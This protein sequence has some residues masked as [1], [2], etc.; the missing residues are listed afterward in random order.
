VSVW[1]GICGSAAC[2]SL[3]SIHKR[4]LRRETVYFGPAR[5]RFRFWIF[6]IPRFSS[7]FAKT[8]RS[9]AAESLLPPPH[10]HGDCSILHLTPSKR[11]RS[12][13][14][15]IFNFIVFLDETICSHPESDAFQWQRQS[16]LLPS[17]RRHASSGGIVGDCYSSM[18][19]RIPPDDTCWHVVYR[20]PP[21]S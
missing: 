2:M 12:R 15:I 1:V 13:L 7:F 8:R 21:L 14:C 6:H 20:L 16:V 19:L 10:H 17:S 3:C 18:R 5:E 11:S 4:I 9:Q